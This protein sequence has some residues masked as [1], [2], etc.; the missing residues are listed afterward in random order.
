MTYFVTK[1]CYNIFNKSLEGKSMGLLENIS[2][3]VEG[4]ELE[5]KEKVETSQESIFEENFFIP[6]WLGIFKDEKD[7]EKDISP[8]LR[9]GR[10]KSILKV[11]LKDKKMNLTLFFQHLIMI[12]IILMRRQKKN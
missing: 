6:A 2:M 10:K 5:D 7:D 3:F 1:N 12:L 9:E 4:E 8:W 11:F